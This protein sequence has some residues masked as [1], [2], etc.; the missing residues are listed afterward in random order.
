MVGDFVAVPYVLCVPEPVRTFLLALE[1][2]GV[3]EQGIWNSVQLLKIVN[4]EDESGQ[5]G[6]KEVKEEKTRQETFVVHSFLDVHDLVLP[7][8]PR[9]AAW[10]CLGMLKVGQYWQQAHSAE[11]NH[12]LRASE[13]RA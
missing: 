11:R 5:A 12:N 6:L 3:A 9:N 4:L 1:L 13:S 8:A 10:Q 2:D 7:A